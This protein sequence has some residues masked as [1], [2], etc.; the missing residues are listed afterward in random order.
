MESNKE[1]WGQFFERYYDQQIIDLAQEYPAE[2][3]LWVDFDKLENYNS[4][5]AQELLATPDT[6]LEHATEALGGME[7]PTDIELTGAIVRMLRID[8]FSYADETSIPPD[9]L[10]VV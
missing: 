1:A 10:S 7:L 9:V 6:V 8:S 3:S 2:R 4:D 5:S